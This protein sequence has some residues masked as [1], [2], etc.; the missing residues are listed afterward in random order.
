V[1]ETILV[2]RLS[3][4]PVVVVFWTMTRRGRVVSLG[5]LTVGSLFALDELQLS[6]VIE[7][8]LRA[9]LCASA[10]FLDYKFIWTPYNASEVHSRVAKRIV[11]C[12]KTN[13]G[14]YVKFGQQLA[15]MDVALPLEFREPLSE[16]HDQAKTFDSEIVKKILN[17]EIPPELFHQL[18]DISEK[19]IASASVA[20][21]HTGFLKDRKVAIKVQKPNIKIQTFW[22]L[23][24]YKFILTSL[25]YFFDIPLLWAFDFIKRQLESE[26]DFR[27]EAENSRQCKIDLEKHR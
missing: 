5:A 27:V 14:L 2:N 17:S 24:M 6:N 15:S 10:I 7:R 21:V 9:L 22:D 16:L 11:K 13:E 8:N 20:Q 3:V 12:C 23:T 1:N 26:L 19:P 25:E 4:C 18:R